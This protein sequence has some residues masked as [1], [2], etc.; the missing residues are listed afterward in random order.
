MREWS[1]SSSG[2]ET[3]CLGVLSSAVSAELSESA[4]VVELT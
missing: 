2:K 3:N 4:D 1:I